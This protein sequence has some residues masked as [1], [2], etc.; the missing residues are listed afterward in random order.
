MWFPYGWIS[1]SVGNGV[2]KCS[3]TLT[4]QTCQG[5]GPSSWWPI[6]IYHRALD[7][8]LYKYSFYLSSSSFFNAYSSPGLISSRSICNLFNLWWIAPQLKHIA[9]ILHHTLTETLEEYAAT[10]WAMG[11]SLSS[12]QP[13]AL[14]WWLP[15]NSFLTSRLPAILGE[16]FCLT[17]WHCAECSS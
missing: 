5:R 14:N 6:K 15:M 4:L 3:H 7:I 2:E 10:K 8:F 16:L 17:L 12:D 11:I 1:S 9:D 13:Q